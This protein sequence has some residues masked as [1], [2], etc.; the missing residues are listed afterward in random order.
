MKYSNNKSINLFKEAQKYLVGGVNSPVRSY[1]AVGGTPIFIESGR[2]QYIYDADGNEYLDFMGSWGPLIF[3]HADPDVVNAI[4]RTVEKGVTFG[5]PCEQEIDLAKLIVDFVPSAEKVRMTNSG[6]EATMSAL[7][8]AR[9]YTGRDYIL[10]FEG[11]YHGHADSLLVKAGSGATTFGNP[12][13]PGVPED[14]VKKTLLANY[15]DIDSVKKR[16]NEHPGEI[17][18]VI[19]EPVPGN[20]GVVIPEQGFLQQL[21]EVTE[22]NDALLIFDEVITGFRIARGGA[23]EF[24]GVTPDLTCLGKIIG[25]GLPVGAYTGRADIMGTVAPEGPVYQAGTL[26]GNPVAMSAGL[27]TLK[28]LESGNV[29]NDLE[30]NT[31]ELVEGIRDIVSRTGVDATVNSLGSMFTVF[32]TD[33]KVYDYST[34]VACNTEKFAQFFKGLISRGMVFPPSQFESVL[35]STAHTK[36]D[37]D[38]ALEIILSVMKEL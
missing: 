29:Y 25:G 19:L 10:K 12:S 31:A 37:I 30:G 17:A 4:K 9:G 3:G 13:S 15:N 1:N 32:F 21:R 5:A 28:K 26:S 18:A 27:A 22:E 14:F 33:K 2:G 8:L 36:N 16:F 7:R 20:M 35:V 11:C 24:Y 34:A 38:N 23:Q 6:T